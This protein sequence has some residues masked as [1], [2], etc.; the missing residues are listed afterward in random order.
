MFQMTIG[1][2]MLLAT[3]MLLLAQLGA[4]QVI[5]E[6]KLNISGSG[7]VWVTEEFTILANETA[8]DFLL[9]LHKNLEIYSNGV[10]VP[11]ASS[12]IDGGV[13]VYLDFS[14][15]PSDVKLRDVLMSYQ[16][17]YLTSKNGSIWSVS[18]STKA[19]PR[20]TILKM[21]LPQN[22]TIVS[23]SPRDVLFSVDRDALWLYPQEPEFNFT[24]NYEYAGGP[25]VLVIEDNGSEK[26]PDNQG[27]V[28]LLLGAFGLAV[29]AFLIYYIL[30]K[31][32]SSKIVGSVEMEKPVV[33][34]GES[35]LSSGESKK[36]GDIGGIEFEFKTGQTAPSIKTTVLNVLDEDERSIVSF[37]QEHGP[38]DITQ[39]FI[40]KTTSM[41][42]S[43]LSEIIKRL[44]KRNVIECHRQGRVNWIKLKKWVL[45]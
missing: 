9:P 36:P 45:E 41:P 37:I 27:M 22:S 19:T 25:D 32:A 23:L 17:Q 2:I 1:K 44:E 31:R 14:N 4:A 20:K 7:L 24:C 39:A 30:R 34:T 10:V 18:F 12:Y 21:H 42:K 35:V 33:S 43:S 11:Y 6:I 38:D 3:V 26:P 13:G 16:T 5:S 15:L 28:F 40:Y 8:V 29:V